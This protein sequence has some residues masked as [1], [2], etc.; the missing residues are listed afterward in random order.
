[1]EWTGGVDLHREHWM[2]SGHGLMDG[3]AARDN[4]EMRPKDSLIHLFARSSNRK[5][6]ETLQ[7]I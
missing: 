6:P 7:T 1:M 2:A 3:D 4:D 5:A